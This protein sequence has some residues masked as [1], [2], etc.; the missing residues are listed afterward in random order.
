MF[1]N[2]VFKFQTEALSEYIHLF[3]TTEKLE[4]YLAFYCLGRLSDDIAI[5]T[6]KC[7]K[8]FF[9][10]KNSQNQQHNL[11]RFCHI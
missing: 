8:H 5:G 2:H 7:E 4:A 11:E 6:F 3:G 10:A 1:L 9:L